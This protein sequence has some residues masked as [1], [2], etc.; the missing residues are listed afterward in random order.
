MKIRIIFFVLTAAILLVACAGQG[1]APTATAPASPAMPT[2]TAA[3]ATDLPATVAPSATEAQLQAS[4]TPSP[5][6]PAA[7]AGAR[8]V[9]V[10]EESEARYR[11]TEQLANLALPNDAVGV[12]N[13][14]SGAVVVNPDGSIDTAQSRLTVNMAS[15]TSDQRNRDNY[16]R[17]NVLRTD[18]YPDAVFVP[19]QVTGLPSPLP[20][21]G[22]VSFQVTGDLTLLDVTRPVTWDVTG[23][24]DGDTAV[25]QA[26]TSFT[27]A[28]FNLTKPSVSIVL[29]LEDLIRLEV[30]VTLRRE[31]GQSGA[32]PATGES[33]AA[34]AAPDCTAPAALTPPMTAGPYYTSNPPENANLYQEGMAGTK[35]T[36]TGYVLDASCRPVP[37][38]RVDFWQADGRGVYDNTGYTL[39]GYQLT[40]AEGRYRLVTV[41]PGQY[42]GRTEHIHVKVQAPGGPELTSQLFFPGA[43]ANQSDRI[44]DESLLVKNLAETPDGMTATFDFVVA[45][46][47]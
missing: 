5:D 39:R 26:T 7:S 35:L 15:L 25:G 41:I 1:A 46:G 28:D 24:I 33:P 47:N 27:F 40:D 21:S 3:A 32:I 10:P 2:Q 6:S 20:E 13:Q 12:T 29:S 16:V 23:T 42:P 17:R 45:A 11:I 19:T 34:A 36:L 30:D 31:G 4:S 43:A 14:I 37:G 18:Q 9:I 38:A 44:F 8:Y 22:P